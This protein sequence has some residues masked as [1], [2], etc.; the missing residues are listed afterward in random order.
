MTYFHILEHFMLLVLCFQEQDWSL[1]RD[2]DKKKAQQRRL[3]AAGIFTSGF[4]FLGT[5][6][7]I[8]GFAKWGK[9]AV[10]V[11]VGDKWHVS[12]QHDQTLMSIL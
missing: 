10:E 11:K 7:L 12:K 9:D 2:S 3:T 6:P 8:I 4:K 1:K 5:P